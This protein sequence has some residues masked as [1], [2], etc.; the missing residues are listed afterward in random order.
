MSGSQRP[1]A[2]HDESAQRSGI[3][4]LAR[5][6]SSLLPAALRLPRA[7]A[8]LL[9]AGWS[10]LLWWGLLGDKVASGVQFFGASYV[11]N[12]AHAGLFGIE[13]LLLGFVL[14]PRLAPTRHRLWLV[15]ALLALAYSA[16]LEWQQGLVPGRTRSLADLLTNCLGVFGLPW[17]L[18]APRPSLG[19]LALW[20]AACAAAGALA[21]F[22]TL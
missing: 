18:R 9:L 19:A 4:S 1:P 22:S 12:L 14:R 15:A 16:W 5:A 11:F 2:S 6:P 10:T 17:A 21:T 20:L 13:A 7:P 8:V 3:A